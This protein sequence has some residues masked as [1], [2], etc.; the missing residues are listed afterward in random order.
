MPQTTAS[1]G[2][3]SPAEQDL[4]FRPSAVA[5]VDWSVV[6]EALEAAGQA[7]RVRGG[8]PDRPVTGAALDSRVVREGDLYVALPGARAHGA[9]FA[10]AAVDAGAAGVL[11]DA[12]GVRI[13]ADLGLGDVPALE[14]D[15]VRDAAGVA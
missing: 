7:V 4:A 15:S 6:A 2:T 12:G 5:P 14:V 1:S 13:L 9:S 8:E 3:P 11:T 10:R